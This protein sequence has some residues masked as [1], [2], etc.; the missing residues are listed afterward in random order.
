MGRRIWRVL[1]VFGNFGPPWRVW[2]GVVT[3]V[4][5]TP[6]SLRCSPRWATLRTARATRGGEAARIAAALGTPLMPWQQHVAD[7][8]LEIDP[9]TGRLAYREVVLTVPPQSGKTALMLAV[10]VHRALGFHSRQRIVYTAQTRI[11]ARKKWED[12]HVLTL[13][14]SK[15][16]GTFSIRKQ[17]GQEAIRWN[18]GSIHSLD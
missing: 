18:N 3:A 11:H 16:R 13:Q 12:E 14:R 17:I 15:F 6:S 8:A 9:A 4:L 7:V 1:R 5:E 2:S 10:M